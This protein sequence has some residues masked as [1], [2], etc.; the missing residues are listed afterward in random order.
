[1]VVLALDRGSIVGVLPAI[2][3][4]DKILS[5]LY[6]SLSRST[7]PTAVGDALARGLLAGA[8][9]AVLLTV[10]SWT[11]LDRF[12]RYNFR[13]R[14][15]EGVVMLDLKQGSQVLFKQLNSKRRANI[16]SAIRHG[17]EVFEPRSEEDIRSFYAVYSAWHGTKRKH[18]HGTKLSLDIFLQRFRLKN[19]F[20]IFLA[21]LS[22]K[23]I[24]GVTLR[25]QGTL[26]EA[27]NNSSLDDFLYSRPND[28]LFWNAIESAGRNGFSRF[29]FGG[30]HRFAREFGGTLTPVYRYRLDRT[31]LHRYDAWERLINT[32]REVL[33]TMPRPIEE[34]VRQLLGKPLKGC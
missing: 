33:R 26:V 3:E 34:A 11:A 23:V 15:L 2:Q 14:M 24:A 19:N 4:E 17:V 5:R 12:E 1:L 21:S 6:I 18:I 30:G 8:G 31:R 27:A 22:G 10:D 28:L 16:R 29:S 32:G 7:D 25:M 9:S 13:S 20:Q